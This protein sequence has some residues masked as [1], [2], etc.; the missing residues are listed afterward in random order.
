MLAPRLRNR[1]FELWTNFWSSGMSNPL[2]AIEQITYLLFINQLEKMDKERVRKGE[3]SIY[4]GELDTGQKD[5]NGNPILISYETCKWSYLTQDPDYDHIRNVVF[6]WLRQID[7]ILYPP[8]EQTKKEEAPQ[9]PRPRYMADASFQL[10]RNKNALLKRAISIIDELFGLSSEANADLMGDIFEFLLNE[11]QSSGKNGQFRTP[12]HIIRFM[13]HLLDPQQGETVMDPASGTAGYL[14][15]TITHLKQNATDPDTLRLEWDGSPQRLECDLD[16]DVYEYLKGGFFEG[17]DNDRTMVRIAWMNMVLHG[18]DQPR[19]FRGDSLSK[20]FQPF[21]DGKQYDCILANPPFTG[22]VDRE[23]LNETLQSKKT[24]KSELLFLWL[25]LDLL[26]LGGRSAVVIPEGVL[27]GSTN[28]HKDLRREL[29]LKHEVEA[30]ISLPGGVFQPYTGVKTS[31][32]IFHKREQ[33][34]TITPYTQKVWFYEIEADGYSLD[35]KRDP[36]PHEP[37]DLWDCEVKYQQLKDVPETDEPDLTYHQPHIYTEWWRE[38]DAPFLEAFPEERFEVDKGKAR[39]RAELFP[40]LPNDLEEAKKQVVTTQWRNIVELYLSF[41]SLRRLEGGQSVLDGSETKNQKKKKAETFFKKE[42]RPLEKLFD[43]TMKA[44]LTQPDKE[45]QTYGKDALEPCLKEAKELVLNNA[46]ALLVA[47]EVKTSVGEF[48]T[49]AILNKDPDD[50]LWQGQVKAIVREFV[51]LDGYQIDLQKVNSIKEQAELLT[52]PKWWVAPVRVWAEDETWE[53]KD[54]AG[55]AILKGSHDEH[56][57]VR[58]EFVA[59]KLAQKDWTDA[60]DPDCIE[61]NDYNLSAGRYKPF[62]LQAVHYDPPA[63]IIRRLQAM[64]TEIQAG[65]ARLLT[66]VEGRE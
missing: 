66:K 27:F 10:D 60:L 57:Q 29:L 22:T 4:E 6:P 31:I 51:K 59:E 64:E 50:N 56:G 8:D 3:K 7:D 24:N 25:I 23:D 26:K 32:I 49:K 37:N 39:S 36:Q 34:E 20:T 46:V 62:T 55:K 44:W 48:N 16:T 5:N 63:E 47:D 41:A 28:A 13:I 30:V 19:I 42:L 52:E 38:I 33:E 14:I 11:I 65:L 2:V 58:P 54:K 53:Q 43:D 15:N 17:Y 61:A 12:R 18:I 35:A 40:A 1:I 21:I 45:V 9:T